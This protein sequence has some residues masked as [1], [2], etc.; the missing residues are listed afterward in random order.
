M[1]IEF[2]FYKMERVIE[3]DDGKVCTALPMYPLPRTAHLKMVAAL[4]NFRLRGFYHS[5]RVKKNSWDA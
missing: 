1:G 3:R 4:G 5:E 2:H